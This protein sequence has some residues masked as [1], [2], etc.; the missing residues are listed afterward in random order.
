M[1]KYAKINGYN[2]RGECGFD[3]HLYQWMEENKETPK[4]IFI[5]AYDV[6][7]KAWCGYLFM[8]KKTYVN[9]EMT[10]DLSDAKACLGGCDIEIVKDFKDFIKDHEFEDDFK[11]F[12]VEVTDANN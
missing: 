6:K 3:T 11:E 9:C 12:T 1:I 5:R 8:K 2:G 10:E 7:P 4:I